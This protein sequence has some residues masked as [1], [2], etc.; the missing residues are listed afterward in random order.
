MTF[1]RFTVV[2]LFAALAASAAGV[3]TAAEL[4]AHRKWMD[5][6]QDRKD[7][8]REALAAKDRAKLLA[9]VK[10]MDGL[11]AREQA[12]WARTNIQQAKDLAVR[13]RKESQALL[14]AAK[15]GRFDEAEKAFAQLEK[16]CTACHDLHFEKDPSL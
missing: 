7:D 12:F 14:V 2:C 4:D 8:I 9:G 1:R 11:T 16:T 10:A 13:N 15:A 3:F 6:A 5:D